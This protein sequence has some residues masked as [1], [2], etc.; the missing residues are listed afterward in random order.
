MGGGG[1]L[2]KKYLLNSCTNI[3]L[4]EYADFYDYSSSYP[5]GD[6]EDADSEVRT[7]NKGIEEIHS[8]FA[9]VCFGSHPHTSADMIAL[10]SLLLCLLSVEQVHV[11]LHSLARREVN[12]TR[13]KKHGTLSFPFNF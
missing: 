12:R 11:G 9:A 6:P 3:M 7:G 8:F 13:A 1:V 4:A 10:S 5:E 2:K